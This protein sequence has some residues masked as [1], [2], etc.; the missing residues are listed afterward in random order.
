[1]I[2]FLIKLLIVFKNIWEN[3]VLL[4]RLNIKSN[5]NQFEER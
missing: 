2:R 5:Y 4:L 3:G 1:M